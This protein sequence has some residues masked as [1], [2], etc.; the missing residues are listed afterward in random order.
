MQCQCIHHWG[1]PLVAE[2]RPD[3]QPTGTEVIVQVVAAGVCH[4]DLNMR[5]GSV[6]LG[7]GQRLDYGA[8]GIGLPLTLGHETVGRVVA[9]GPDAGEIDR[10]KLYV[11]FPWCGCGACDV[12]R[13]GD[14]NLCAT[15]RF[16]GIHTDG[17]YATQI[18]IAHPRYLFDI[19]TLSPEQAAPLACSGL[20]TFSGLKKL[21]DGPKT[22]PALLIGAGGLGLMCIQL[23][24]ALGMLAPVVADIDPAKR[25]AALAAGARAAIDPGA[26]DAVAAIARAC[27]GAPTSVLDFVG[28]E[29][30]AKLGFDALGKGGTLVT[31]G[32]FGGAAPWSLPMITLKSARIIGVYVGSLT[33]FGALMELARNGAIRPIPTRRFPLSQAD[34][35]L[36]RLHHGEIVGR[37]ILTA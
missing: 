12:C 21:G 11:L 7:R 18:R 14:E 6:D 32:L 33:E 15:P 16:L 31:I 2:D 8:R 24:Q 5:T 13:A 25:A 9:T 35:V 19:G 20:T 29:A 1:Q 4:T 37:A 3:L 28:A 22:Q 36:D 23:M 26:P 30:T 27:G 34:A 10:S 17:G